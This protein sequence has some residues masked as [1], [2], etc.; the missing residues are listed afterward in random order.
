MKGE[1]ILFRLTF[2]P[3]QQMERTMTRMPAMMAPAT[4]AR[5]EQNPSSQPAPIWSTYGKEY[6]GKGCGPVHF[7]LTT[8][9]TAGPPKEK[10]KRFE[11]G[12]D[13]ESYITS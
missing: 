2:V 13:L 7:P 6:I 11:S 8:G 3:Q 5:R 9:K 1:I 12:P 10:R 4:T